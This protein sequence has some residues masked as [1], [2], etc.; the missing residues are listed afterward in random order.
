MSASGLALT[1]GYG[2]QQDQ[3]I[4]WGWR[5]PLVA[6]IGKAIA[7][8]CVQRPLANIQIFGPLLSSQKY[9]YEHREWQPACSSDCAGTCP[10]C[11]PLQTVLAMGIYCAFKPY[12]D[13]K[14]E[15]LQ[16][17]LGISSSSTEE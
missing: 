11:G 6:C 14:I 10:S 9:D 5:G 7:S 15:D 4:Y 12:F 17:W 16:E 8:D 13:R 1:F 3:L 2:L